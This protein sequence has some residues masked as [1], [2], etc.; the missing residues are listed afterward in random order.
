MFKKADLEY[1]VWGHIGNNHVHVNILPRNEEEYLKGKEL[2]T[3]WAQNAVDAGGAVSAEYG[4]GKL[5][6]NFL[7][8]MYGEQHIR[9]MAEM[10]YVFDK[11]GLLGVGNLFEEQK[12]IAKVK[13]ENA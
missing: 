3:I 6:A 12:M 1:A 10:K 5:K 13:I 8:L 7:A 2:Y 9:E 11:K 4:V